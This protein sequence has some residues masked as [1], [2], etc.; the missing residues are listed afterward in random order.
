MQKEH[1]GTTQAGEETWLYTL[2]NQNG[3]SI[4]VTN[5]G[6][7]ITE[8]N[9]PDKHGNFQDIALGFETLADFEERSPFFG[10]IIGR[11]A[12]RI[13]NG[14][15]AIGDKVYQLVQN[16]GPNNLHGGP[17]GFDKKVWAVQERSTDRCLELHYHSADGEAGF[18]GNLWVSVNYA[19]TE[20]NELHIDY[21]AGTDQTTPINLTNH[22]YFNLAGGGSVLEHLVQLDADQMTPVDENLIPTGEIHPV[23]GTPFDFR[24]MTSVGA[25][26]DEGHIQLQRGSG[27]D[28]NFCLNHP[29]DLSRC[30]AR[31]IE[32]QSGRTLEMYT[33]EPGV[34]FYT[35]NALEHLLGKNG[36]V[37]SPRTGFCLEAQKYPD[38]PNQ[39]AFPSP[40]LTPDGSYQ[41]TTIYRF[42]VV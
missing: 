38:S 40:W 4:K 34:Q 33:T 29:G 42:G 10:C 41:Q 21:R 39:P 6:G 25:R 2:T 1:F 3:I 31:V 22:T 23:A 16:N 32:P 17:D 35:G 19:L 27:Y 9:V 14:R 12:N 28:H 5:F 11:Y 36:E 8:I 20:D 13:A 7:T 30:V 37:W 18:P 24:E 26:I 15:F